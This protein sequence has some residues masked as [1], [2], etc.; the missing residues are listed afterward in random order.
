MVRWHI[1]KYAELIASLRDTAE[2]DGSLLDNC[3]IALLIEGGFR[4]GTTSVPG[5]NSHTTENMVC[6]VSGGAGGLVRGQHIDAAG[7]HPV[8]VLLTLM[9]AVGVPTGK[10]GDV[11]GTLPALFA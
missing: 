10:L 2:G 4:A 7:A 6:L 11:S 8:N 3:A 5:G 1:R 9:Q